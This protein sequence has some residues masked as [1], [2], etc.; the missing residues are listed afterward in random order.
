MQ[1]DTLLKIKWYLQRTK[2]LFIN[3]NVRLV[4][5]HDILK[6][7]YKDAF[8]DF[9]IKEKIDAN[10]KKAYKQIKDFCLDIYYN[11]E[12]DWKPMTSQQIA[13]LLDCTDGQVRRI[14]SGIYKKCNK[15]GEPVLQEK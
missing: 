15:N 2:H 3:G 14:L 12:R 7:T 9:T 8:V 4:A 13:E 5:E 11:N 1:S 10:D 6:I